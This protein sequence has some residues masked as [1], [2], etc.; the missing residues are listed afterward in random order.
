VP[1]STRETKRKP[2]WRQLYYSSKLVPLAP[3]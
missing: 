3:R 1:S 2:L